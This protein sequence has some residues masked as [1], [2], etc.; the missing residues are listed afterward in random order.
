M[1]P[2]GSQKI[3]NLLQFY[4]DFVTRNYNKSPC[5]FTNESIA[6]CRIWSET[7]FGTHKFH[8]FCSV[9]YNMNQKQ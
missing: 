9:L 8:E 1:D 3:F 5:N 4:L 2:Q 7:F 6:S